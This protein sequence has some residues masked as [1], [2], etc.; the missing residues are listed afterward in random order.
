MTS[1]RTL[2][3]TIA[4]AILTILPVLAS[5]CIGNTLQHQFVHIDKDGWSRNDTVTFDLPPATH[6]GWYAIDTEIRTTCPFQYQSLYIV[7][8]LTLQVPLMTQKDTIRIETGSSL[9]TS[10]KKGV[11][12]RCYN[13]CDTTLFLREGQKGQMKLYHIMSLEVLPHITDIGITVKA[14]KRVKII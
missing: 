6:E 1:R 2:P 14:E 5:S 7:R 4:K 3:R 9:A 12:L 11:T 8:E 13:H 10:D